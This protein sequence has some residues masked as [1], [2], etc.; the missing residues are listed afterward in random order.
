M[1]IT[2]NVIIDL[3]ATFLFLFSFWREDIAFNPKGVA[4][5]PSPKILAII[6]LAIRLKDSSPLGISGNNFVKI[7]IVNVYLGDKK[8]YKEDIFVK[9]KANKTKKSTSKIKEWF[10]N[11]W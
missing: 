4:A 3:E 2:K 1:F 6:L 10:S 9:G 5:L 11:L 7:G 8:I